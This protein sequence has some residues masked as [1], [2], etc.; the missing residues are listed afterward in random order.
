MLQAV[1]GQP[2]GTGTARGA[3][4]GR[5]FDDGLAQMFDDR[6]EETVEAIVRGAGGQFRVDESLHRC[7]VLDVSF[8]PIN[9]IGWERALCMELLG[10]ADVLEIH[11]DVE[12]HSAHA[13]F[14][15]PAVLRVR[16]YLGKYENRS[17]NPTRRNVLLPDENQCQY[18]GTRKGPITIDHVVPLV[19]GGK[20]TWTNLVAACAKCNNR[21]GHKHLKDTGMRLKREPREPHFVGP[22]IPKGM[23]THPL[24]APYV[25]SGTRSFLQ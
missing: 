14:M 11:E 24:W 22:T 7:L 3:G 8:Q 15:L 1:A 20:G 10:K 25:A 12:V 5:S 13:S 6:I 17:V 9:V 21:K 16:E 4:P 19:R 23:R 2:N 18:C